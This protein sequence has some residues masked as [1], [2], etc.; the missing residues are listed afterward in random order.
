MLHWCYPY[1]QPTT[2]L[3]S[4][5]FNTIPLSTKHILSSLKIN[6]SHSFHQ[7]F[8]KKEKSLCLRISMIL[9][10]GNKSHCTAY[11]V[12]HKCFFYFIKIQSSIFSR[13]NYNL[14]Y[15]PNY[16]HDHCACYPINC[17]SY[18][19][20]WTVYA[21]PLYSLAQDYIFEFIVIRIRR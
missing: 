14:F 16:P 17:N 20:K 18:S 11:F 12:F 15:F 19:I 1:K 3:K 6:I 21:D 4:T 7:V 13:R 8:G 9:F 10:L 5:S 2:I